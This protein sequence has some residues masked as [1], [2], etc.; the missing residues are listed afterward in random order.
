MGRNPYMLD[1][2]SAQEIISLVSLATSQTL[3]VTKTN[4]IRQIEFAM[5]I[6]MPSIILCL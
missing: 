2:K 1:K 4:T 6:E 3:C 5:P